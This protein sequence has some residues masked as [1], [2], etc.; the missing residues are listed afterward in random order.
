MRQLLVVTF[1]IAIAA[2]GDKKPGG[3]DAAVP[4]DGTNT[5]DGAVDCSVPGSC[6]TG[7]CEPLGAACGTAADCCSLGC[8]GGVCVDQLCTSAGGTCGSD[9]DCCGNACDNGTCA[10]GGACKPA[11]EDCTTGGDGA[12]C[13]RACDDMTKRCLAGPMCRVEGEVCSENNDCCN[14]TCDGGTCATMGDCAMVGESCNTDTECCGF[15]CIDVVNSGVKSC[16]YLGGCRTAGELCRKD[17]DCCNDAATNQ[18]GVCMI[19]NAEEGVG[20]CQNPGGCAPTGE[21]CATADGTPSGSNQCCPQ[22]VPAGDPNPCVQTAEGP[23]RCYGCFITGTACDDNADC[24]NGTCNNGVCGC[25]GDGQSC[26]TADEC[27]S[28]VCAPD[29]SGN[30][31]CAPGCLPDAATCTANGDCCGGYCDPQTL[32]CSTIIQ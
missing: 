9:S 24:C 13:S 7:A 3:T 2:C 30:L 4:G 28:K 22:P 27:C 10:G 18:P 21:V 1:L 14:F 17:T 23:Y 12:C 32:T 31:V 15:S 26:Q 20:R 29:G 6:G 8:S 11:G 16:Q 5:D 25:T 19:Y